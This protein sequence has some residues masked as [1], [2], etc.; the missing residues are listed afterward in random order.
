MKIKSFLDAVLTSSR[1]LLLQNGDVVLDRG[2]HAV[3]AGTKKYRESGLN[4]LNKVVDAQ[5]QELARAGVLNLGLNIVP[6]TACNGN[7]GVQVRC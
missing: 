7:K 3:V 6:T 5:C 1:L 4:I 2:R